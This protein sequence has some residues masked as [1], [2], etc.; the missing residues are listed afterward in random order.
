MK[1]S[2]YIFL[3]KNLFYFLAALSLLLNACVNATSTPA[4]NTPVGLPTFPGPLLPPTPTYAMD[5]FSDLPD[6]ARIATQPGDPR[7]PTYWAE[8]NRCAE[9]NQ[10]EWAD[11]NG[12]RGAGWTLMDDLLDYPGIQL[13]D[14]PVLSC[15]AGLNLLLGQTA[16]GE[17]TDDP[18]YALASV[19]LAA[20]LNL[21]VGSENCPIAEEATV[22]GHL[23]LSS[24]KFNGEGSYAGTISEE[25]ANAIPRLVELLTGY[26][27]GILCR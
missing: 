13:G 9:E 21:N 5:A 19:L 22:G 15:E 6:E 2:N 14:Y 8:W 18:I 16:A 27:S 20:E 25:A 11:A 24:G 1:P 23:I 26:N 12:G 4:G 10:S 3:R 7:P 17:E